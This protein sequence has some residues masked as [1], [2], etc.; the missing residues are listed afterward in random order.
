MNHAKN[1]DLTIKVRKKADVC[2]AE[3]REQGGVPHDVA[4]VTPRV[5]AHI[6]AEPGEDA[7][8]TVERLLSAV[9]VGNF[10]LR[11]DSVEVSDA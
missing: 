4:I 6:I 11:V 7:S 5:T 10:E 1:N 3:A 2:R 9:A 8:L